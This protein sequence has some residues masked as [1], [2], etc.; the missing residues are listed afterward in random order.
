MNVEDDGSA[1]FEVPPMKAV[2]FQALDKDGRVIQRMRTFTQ[3]MGGEVQSCTGCHMDRNTVAPNISAKIAALQKPIQKVSGAPWNEHPNAFSYQELVQT[4]WDKNCVSCHNPFKKSGGLDLS[5]DRTDLFNMSYDNLVRTDVKKIRRVRP[6][7][8]EFKHKYIS[9]IPSYNGCEPKYGGGVFP[10]E[11]L[12]SY[13]SKLTQLIYNGHPDKNGK[14][15]INLSDMEKRQVYAWVDYN[16]PYYQAIQV[17][18]EIRTECANWFLMI[19][20]KS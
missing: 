11:I 10:A 2:F 16:V 17:I 15:R 6:L 5:G 12:G 9:Y 14:P 18:R 13:K 20:I 4:V 8:Y 1:M 7:V 19:F 3:F